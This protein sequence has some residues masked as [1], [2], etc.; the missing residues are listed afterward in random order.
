MIKECSKHGHTNFF[1][2][3]PTF[4]CNKCAVEA[5]Q[6]RR[7]KLK[8]MALE[9]KG[10]QCE[11]CGYSKCSNAL[12]FHHKNPHDKDFGIAH[13]GYT[14]A[15]KKVKSELDKCLLLCANCHAEVHS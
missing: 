7:N 14:R 4:R 11:I 3:G 12:V 15:W 2:N 9:Y 6:R 5:V 8:A 10:G 1:R 13:K